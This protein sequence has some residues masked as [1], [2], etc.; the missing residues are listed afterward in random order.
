M[1]DPDRDQQ[2]LQAQVNNA[3]VKWLREFVFSPQRLR[4][5][6]NV[7]VVVGELDR[8]KTLETGWDGYRATPIEPNLVEAA[9]AFVGTLPIDTIATPLVVPMTRGRLQFEWHKGARSLEME[10]EKPGAIHYLKTDSD[11]GEEDEDEISL[12][13]KERLMGLLKWFSRGG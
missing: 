11:T 7:A 9:K 3:I 4:T 13:E 10:F 5:C 8:L 6:L 12:E 2:S 1:N